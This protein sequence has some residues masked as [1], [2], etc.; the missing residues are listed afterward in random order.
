MKWTHKAGIGILVFIIIALLLSVSVNFWIKYQLPK[1]IGEKNKSPYSITYKN[2]N[3][4]LIDGYIKAE[5]IVILPKTAVEDST[6]KSGIYAKVNSIEVK[7]FKIWSVLFSDRIKAHS[8]TI[9][10]PEV[11]LYKKSDKTVNP[12]NIRNAVVAPFEKVISVKDIY[13]YNGDIKI[14]YVKTKKAILSIS[15]INIRLDG[16]AVDD[17]TLGRKIPFTFEKYSVKCDSLYYRANE[18]YHFTTQKITATKSDLQIS[19]FKMIPEY[20][21]RE[22]VKKI[23]K[24]K[25][26]FVISAKDIHIKNLDWGFDSEVLFANAN[27]VNLDGV[28]ADIYR[29]KLPEDDLSK[30]YLYNK[31]LRDLDFNMKVDTLKVR[32]SLLAYEEEKDFYKG[33]GKLVFN[34]FDLTAVNIRS[35]FQKKKLPDLKIHISCRFMDTSPMKVDWK[36]NV[37][38]K[39]DGFNIR[40][41]IMDFDSKKIAAFS[42]PYI[43][44][45]TEG[46]L[47]EVYFNFTGNDAKAHGEFAIKYDDFK[48]TFYQK[49]N[50]EKKNKFLT[51]VGNL[52]VKNDTKGQVKGT[53]VELERIPEKSFYNFFWRSIAEGLKKIF[54]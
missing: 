17:E 39:T 3:Y 22:F 54:I 14:V 37:M 2:L 48:V 9:I 19:T 8:I 44:A 52:F 26:L 15:N 1:I 45:T 42:K 53:K 30:K 35:G 40:G 16:I 46:T 6:L 27:S 34:K 29:N 7:D 10:K 33:S 23:P 28:S 20:T 41:S 36:L 31:L 12:K 38:D 21:R 51:A 43:N 24:E 4:S 49:N 5:G 47:N 13:L 50:R 11:I 18:F 32:H 25:D